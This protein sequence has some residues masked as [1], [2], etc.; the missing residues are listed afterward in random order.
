MLELEEV[1]Q[2]FNIVIKRCI[3]IRRF[4]SAID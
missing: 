2:S 3:P 1:L 4:L